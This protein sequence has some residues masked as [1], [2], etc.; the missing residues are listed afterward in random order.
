MTVS[1]AYGERILAWAEALSR[2]SDHESHL[3]CTYLTPAHRATAEQLAAWMREAGFDSVRHDPVGNV[4]GRYEADPTVGDPRL[5]VTGSHY[6][7]VRN[8]GRYDGRLGI[9]LPIA[10]V[11]E[12]RRQGRRLPYD[13]E[14]VGFAEEE[15]ARFGTSFLASSAYIGAF[16]PQWL[17]LADAAGITMRQAMM[18]AGLDP[19]AIAAAT[20]DTGRL[21]HY[22]EVHIEQGPV[23]LNAGLPLGVVTSIAGNVRRRLLLQGR[24]GHAGTTPMH[25]RRDAACA[26]AEIALYV[27]SRC[28]QAETLVGTVG[29]LEVPSGSVNVIPGACRLSLDIRA[30]DDATRDAAVADVMAKVDEICRRRDIAWEETQPATSVPAAPCSPEHR[31]LWREVLAAQGHSVLELPSGAGHDAM[32]LGRVVP[33]SMLFVRCGNGG[34]S[35]NPLETI[36]AEDAQL[37]GAAV[38]GFLL[39]LAARPA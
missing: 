36:T 26:A 19:S 35:H 4:V 18:D 3:T 34:I 27:E 25:M 23:L 15:G 8:G 28:G 1:P 32:I 31:T 14:V 9:L 6:D 21:Q 20:V 10:V 33:Q 24:A 5:V 30:A 2:W 37:A 17:D 16:K 29:I 13:F 7:T 11:A 39:A 22:F 38:E 12:L